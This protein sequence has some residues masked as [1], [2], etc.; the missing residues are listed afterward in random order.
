MPAGLQVWGAD[1]SP[2]VD[3]TTRLPRFL[4]TYFAGAGAS[5]T[6]THPGLLTGQPECFCTMHATGIATWPGDNLVPPAVSFSGD[7]MSYGPCNAAT[8][9]QLWVF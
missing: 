6:I 7:T 8:R 2:K 5:G 1:G 3:I 4:G 9:F